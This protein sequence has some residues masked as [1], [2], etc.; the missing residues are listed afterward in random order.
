MKFTKTVF[1]IGPASRD[2]N[3][4]KSLIFE[5][6]DVARLNFSHEDF[7]AHARS[8]EYVRLASEELHK[9]VGIFQDLQ[10]PKIRI[11]KLKTEFIELKEDG[12][13][14]ITTDQIEGDEK[15]VSIDYPYLHE[16]VS[17]GSRILLDDGLMELRVESIS[18]KDIRCKVISGGKLKPRKGVNLPHIRLHKIS[19]ITEKDRADLAFSFEQDLD[20]VALSFVRSSADVKELKE[21]MKS[22]YGRII[23]VISKIEK[24]EAVD[25][26]D[27]II[28]VSDA[29]MVA[30][31]DLGVETS[32]EDVPMIQKTLIRKCNLVGKP[33]ITATQML[34]SMITN[35]RPTRAEAN[36]VANAILDGSSAVMLSGETAAGKYPV[37]SVRMMKLIAQ[38]TESSMQFRKLVLGKMLNIDD[39]A[40]RRTGNYEDAVGHAAVDLAE[41]IGAQFIVCF[42]HGGGTARLISKY[43]PD[44]RV[45][46]FSPLK[47]TVRQ[48]AL[49]WGIH[50]LETREVNTVDEL[51]D[52]AA[53]ALK[54]K[55]WVEPGQTIVI[56][57]GVPVGKPGKTNM[58]KVVQIE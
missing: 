28:D 31:G 52:G 32:P 10:G 30:R 7:A 50:P 56:T 46:G 13:L 37:E 6:G 47:S 21:L 57:A 34:E 23:P 11:G 39:L 9:P 44:I 1:T 55:G 25:D 54:F 24:P 5:G 43:R 26:I 2:P 12:E 27:N 4:I 53:E 45:I 51:L 41:E 48:L 40:A 29:I 14:I 42:T 19:S 49:A 35:P 33:V 38:K 18:G 22:K 8:V 16:E 15:R 3:T 17:P 36:D 20:F 58:V